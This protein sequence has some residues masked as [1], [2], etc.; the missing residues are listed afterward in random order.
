MNKNT[1][2]YLRVREKERERERERKAVKR[3]IC[4]IRKKMSG[5]KVISWIS[6]DEMI[7]GAKRREEVI[8]VQTHY[9]IAV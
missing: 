1:G 8:G 6:R 4:L 3:P 5:R 2:H 9:D 7:K